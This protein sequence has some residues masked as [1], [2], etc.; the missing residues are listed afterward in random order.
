[1]LNGRYEGFINR[2]RVVSLEMRE[3]HPNIWNVV[4]RYGEWVKRQEWRWNYFFF[5]DD[6]GE[7]DE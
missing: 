3:Q 5:N 6:A 1:M 4:D 2:V 7:V